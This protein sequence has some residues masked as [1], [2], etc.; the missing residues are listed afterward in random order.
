MAIDDDSQL[1]TPPDSDIY[2]RRESRP[3][4]EFNKRLLAKAAMA[5]DSKEENMRPPVIDVDSQ[6]KPFDSTNVVDESLKK[7]SSAPQPQPPTQAQDAI[8]QIEEG[9]DAALRL[10][11]S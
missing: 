7:S 6:S 3:D 5:V 1:P 8:K 4:E 10:F 2:E 11:N 9:N